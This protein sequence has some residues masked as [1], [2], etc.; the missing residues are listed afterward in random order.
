M[1]PE[2]SVGNGA[3]AAMPM[4]AGGSLGV[5]LRPLLQGMASIPSTLADAVWTP[6]MPPIPSVRP[7]GGDCWWRTYR[8]GGAGAPMCLVK[9]DH[10]SK[11]IASKGHW[12]DCLLLR[13]LW[14]APTADGRQGGLFLDIGSNIGSCTME[15][16]L[17]TDATII[18]VTAAIELGACEHTPRRC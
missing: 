5:G 15:F 18:A 9:D 10:I 4:A 1:R 2:E 6:D 13:R 16:L 8:V 11:A 7:G 3:E 12:Y 17:Y 14:Y